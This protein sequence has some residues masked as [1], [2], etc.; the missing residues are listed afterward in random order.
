MSWAIICG[1]RCIAMFGEARS[2]HDA[3]HRARRNA[4]FAA[5]TAVFQHH[6][7]LALCTDDG[8]DRAGRQAACATDAA[9]RVD[10]HHLRRGLHAT[11]RVQRQRGRVEQFG[12]TLDGVTATRWA[13]VDG[14][15]ATGEGLRV[16]QAAVVTA[17]GALRLRQ[18]RVNGFDAGCLPHAT[19]LN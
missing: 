18:Q 1:R 10:P 2:Q 14:G 6:V 3:V 16:G 7:Q 12:E 4:K 9:L 17:A 5:C 15:L 8:I 13:A 19:T 11:T